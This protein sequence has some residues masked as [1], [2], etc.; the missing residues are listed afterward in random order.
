MILE[1]IERIYYNKREINLRNCVS[2][3]W[4]TVFCFI[5][6]ISNLIVFKM[7]IFKIN[8]TIENKK[9]NPHGLPLAYYTKTL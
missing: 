6:I 5:M 8:R 1:T 9:G 3:L 7:I 4:H 2:A